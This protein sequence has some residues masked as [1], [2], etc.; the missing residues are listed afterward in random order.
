MEQVCRASNVRCAALLRRRRGT[1]ESAHVGKVIRYHQCRN[2][3]ATRSHEKRR[4]K[5]VI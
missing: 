1:P 2:E 4:H 5:C 3:Q